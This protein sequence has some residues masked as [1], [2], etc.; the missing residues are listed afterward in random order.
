MLKPIVVLM[1]ASLITVSLLGCGGG[2]GG[3]GIQVTFL[4]PLGNPA[5]PQ[6]TQ[7]TL[8]VAATGGTAGIDRVVFTANGTPVGTATTSPYTVIWNTDGYAVGAYNVVATAYDNSAPE[9]SGTASITVNL[10]SSGVTVA[11]TSPPEA[12]RTVNVGATV[13]LAVTVSAPTSVQQVEFY[14]NGTLLTTDLA[15]PWGYSWL[16]TGL[17]AGS[18]TILAKAYDS[19]VPP[20]TGSASIV[21]Q[22]TSGGSLNPTVQITSPLSGALV[23]GTVVIN[24]TA[25]AQASGAT[26]AQVQATMGGQVQNVAGGTQTVTD[27]VSFNTLGMTDGAQTVVITATDSGARTGSASVTLNVSNGS[28]PPPPPF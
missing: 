17:P 22:I 6:G 16:T 23:T 21:I 18:Y 3:G 15:A 14:A 13:P 7:I 5:Y 26:I 1:I 9:Q 10:E 28:G 19:S 12:S 25:Q 20:K 8:Q 24:F 11:F 4:A 2:G 27:S